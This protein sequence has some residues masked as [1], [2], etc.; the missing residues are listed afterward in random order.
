[1]SSTSGAFTLSSCA[2][3][4]QTIIPYVPKSVVF[5]DGPLAEALHWTAGAASLFQAGA[6]NIKEFSSFESCSKEEKKGVFI[7]SGQI[8]STKQEI[9]EDIIKASHFQHCTLITS[10]PESLHQHLTEDGVSGA[11]EGNDFSLF[12]DIESRMRG[13]MRHKSTIYEADVVHVPLSVACVSPTLF[14]LPSF[15]SLFPL[16]DTDMPVIKAHQENLVERKSPES[17]TDVDI[18][19]LPTEL[20]EDLKMLVSTLS[21][22]CETLDINED[23]YCLGPTSRM[24]ATELAHLTSARNRRKAATKR[25]SIL[26]LDRTLDLVG[27]TC[28]GRESLA[29]KIMAVLP[30]LNG[31]SCDVAVDMSDLCSNGSK[32]NPLVLAPGCLAHPHH[33]PSV[34]LVKAL[35]TAKQ[36]ESLMDVNRRVVETITRERLPFDPAAAKIGRINAGSL[37]AHL[38]LFKGSSSAFRNSSP[39]LQLGLACV[40]T[41]TSPTLSRWDD[42][43]TSEKL[44]LQSSG[45]GNG[46]SIA[47][48]LLDLLQNPT[49]QTRGYTLEEAV[50]LI[51]HGYSLVGDEGKGSLEKERQ[52]Q[53]F[54]SQMLTHAPDNSE[55][56][57]LLVGENR[58]EASSQRAAKEI[59]LKA[60]SISRARSHLQKFDDLL[61]PGSLSQPASFTPL[62][63][64]VMEA[65]FDPA[66]PDLVD[67]EYKSSGFRDLL[68]TGFRLFMNVGK[69]RP[70]DHN[71]LLVFMVG[72]ITCSEVKLIKDSVSSLSPNTEVIVGST[73]ILREPDVLGHVF[74]QTSLSF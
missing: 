6:L 4:W 58:S 43:H 65:I 13:W 40:H 11:G 72:G 47:S 56:L 18:G 60:K 1:M 22:L 5:L 53:K 26:F 69:P 55:L 20:Q 21:C 12:C 71:L 34:D 48:L 16:L 32:Y 44:M 23:I 2:K 15:T 57:R 74:G 73:R 30:A 41:L 66:K 50:L 7:I 17:L 62:V 64:Q 46:R 31:H 24:I 51:L 29:D 67:I 52:L 49:K 33:Q 28:H 14:F 39:L 9:L 8:C 68:K 10:L 63:K 35:I 36:K 59:L 54:V 3:T 61:Q 38:Q 70:S 45:E 42:L 27:P 25:A 19:M 37:R